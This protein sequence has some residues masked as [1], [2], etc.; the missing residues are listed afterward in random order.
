MA[1]PPS[2]SIL[3]P[4]SIHYRFN[5]PKLGDSSKY[6][7]VHFDGAVLSVLDLKRTIMF[8]ADLLTCKETFDLLLTNST[9]GEEFREEGFLVPRNSSLIIRRVPST[10]DKSDRIRIKPDT[11]ETTG[12][13]RDPVYGG[14]RVLSLVEQ[15]DDS[16]AVAS[17]INSSAISESAPDVHMPGIPDPRDELQKSI[18]GFGGSGPARF[19]NRFD[20]TAKPPPGYICHRCGQSG[21]FIRFCPTNDD[22]TY[23][24][25]RPKPATG[26]PRSFLQPIE[27]P[28]AG[29]GDDDTAK[30]VLPDN[31]YAVAMPN[32][33]QF[34]RSLAEKGSLNRLDAPTAGSGAGTQ[35]QS[36][37]LREELYCSLC[38]KPFM[39]AVLTP[40]CLSTFCDSCIRA[41]LQGSE[42]PQ[43][44]TCCSTDC[45][46][47]GLQPNINFQNAVED[48]LLRYP[49]HRGVTK[50][51]LANQQARVAQA[52]A[53]AQGTL[54]SPEFMNPF[55]DSKLR[56][57]QQ[58]QIAAPLPPQPRLQPQAIGRPGPSRPTNPNNTC[59]RCGLKG[60]YAASCE[61]APNP[62]A[63]RPISGDRGG[64]NQ[65]GPLQMMP[66]GMPQMLPGGMQLAPSM[67]PMQPGMQLMAPGMQLAAFGGAQMPMIQDVRDVRDVR[68]GNPSHSETP[69]YSKKRSRDGDSQSRSSHKR[70]RSHSRSHSPRR[71]RRSR[72][73][74][75]RS[76]RNG[77][78]SR[79]RESSS[80]RREY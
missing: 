44:P 24:F 59:F 10:K 29:V 1:A 60:H 77:S 17:F 46:T 62:N 80:R 20:P 38:Q 31:T 52:Q 26:I 14:G 43:C 78:S 66:G 34:A 9:T 40:C 57:G 73:R 7:K 50:V 41:F 18:L 22:P 28:A 55:F 61:N 13:T 54:A 5:D 72:H 6:F 2:S 49:D 47:D 58:Q 67:I 19:G 75:S 16:D 68:N 8:R 76:E 69:R 12:E 63:Y 37:E 3:G 79:Y 32:Q 51:Q 35:E 11:V 53:T 45:S 70:N 25:R 71:E 15:I 30:L 74:D 36:N 27:A 39:N 33:R 21:H 23:N 48:F 56:G 42:H 64:P 4:S 65:T